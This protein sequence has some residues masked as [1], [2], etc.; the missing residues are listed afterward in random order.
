MSLTMP[1]YAVA[2]FVT[3]SG[4]RCKNPVASREGLIATVAHA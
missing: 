2:F 3:F 4:H 1:V